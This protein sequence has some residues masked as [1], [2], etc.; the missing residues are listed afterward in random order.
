[1]LAVKPVREETIRQCDDCEAEVEP[2]VVEVYPWY[3]AKVGPT[4]AR[5]VVLCAECLEG[6]H[7]E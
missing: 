2:R 1:M 7:N 4:E 3:E 6:G 5:A